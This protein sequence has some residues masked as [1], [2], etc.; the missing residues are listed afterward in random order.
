M[1]WLYLALAV[2]IL[3]GVIAIY[4]EIYSQVLDRC[5]RQNQ[6][7]GEPWRSLD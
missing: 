6:A 2:V 5:E 1:L 4:V 3:I 7:H